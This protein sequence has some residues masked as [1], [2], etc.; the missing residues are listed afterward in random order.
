MPGGLPGGGGVFK[1][2]FDR[3]ITTVM[4]VGNGLFYHEFLSFLLK[5]NRLIKPKPQ[6]NSLLGVWRCHNNFLQV[7]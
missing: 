4:V 3:Y 5:K 6:I 7:H 1:L 2:L